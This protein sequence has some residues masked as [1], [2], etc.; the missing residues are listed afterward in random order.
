MNWKLSF[1][2]VVTS[3]AGTL[4]TG[5]VGGYQELPYT[6]GNPYGYSPPQQMP[7]GYQP[8]QTSPGAN[9]GQAWDG[10]DPSGTAGNQQQP[11]A[12]Q[13]GPGGG[14]QPQ[15][16]QDQ[17]GQQPQTSGGSDAA[18]DLPSGIPVPGKPGFVTSPYSDDGSQINVQGYPSGTPVRDP[19]T[20]GI[21]I[22]P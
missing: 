2:V 15:Q 10:S 7:P 11:G 19:Y 8:A 9:Y 3:L 22:V 1:A 21:F 14:F 13:T 5:C 20:G 18:R 17:S 16:P 12:G 6:G 4:L